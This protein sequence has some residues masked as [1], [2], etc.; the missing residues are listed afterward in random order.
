MGFSAKDKAKEIDDVSRWWRTYPTGA[1]K[2]K[3]LKSTQPLGVLKSYLD[4]VYEPARRLVRSASAT[5]LTY[6]RDADVSTTP[7]RRTTSFSSLSPSH[8]LHSSERSAQRLIPAFTSYQ[9][10]LAAYHQAVLNFRPT[11][12]YTSPT[13]LKVRK[14]EFDVNN[15][16]RKCDQHRFQVVYDRAAEDQRKSY[17]RIR[18]EPSRQRFYAP[19][20][21]PRWTY[22]HSWYEGR[23]KG[24]E[25]MSPWLYRNYDRQ[26]E[27]PYMSYMTVRSHSGPWQLRK[28][29]GSWHSFTPY[30]LQVVNYHQHYRL[31]SFSRFARGPYWKYLVPSGVLLV[32]LVSCVYHIC[33]ILWITTIMF[34]LI[35]IMRGFV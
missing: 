20:S 23:L 17:G 25:R 11:R 10:K 16:R 18:D 8:S 1:E 30:R 35:I 19:T 33:L 22:S 34:S 4:D 32:V 26:E 6:T 2:G 3:W 28:W 14:T 31:W 27:R 7:L 13:P 21:W 12:P 5:R 24:L 15:C 29:Q 9:P